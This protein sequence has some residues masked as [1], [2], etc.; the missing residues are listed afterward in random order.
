MSSSYNINDPAVN[1]FLSA[2]YLT[3]ATGSGAVTRASVQV[4]STLRSVLTPY[5]KEIIE[6]V[7][8]QYNT[9]N[10][11][12]HNHEDFGIARMNND[13]N[14]VCAYIVY[15]LL[16]TIPLAL[17]VYLQLGTNT[18]TGFNFLGFVGSPVYVS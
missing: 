17:R 5:A 6:R 9:D 18:R 4:G 14:S 11:T 13:Q 10:G 16:T 2:P 12:V 3:G 15:P 1:P 7:I 8:T